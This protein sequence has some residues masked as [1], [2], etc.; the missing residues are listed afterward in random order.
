MSALLLPLAGC[1]RSTRSVMQTH[2][3][4]TVLDATLTDLLKQTDDRFNQIKSMNASIDISVSTGG[5][6]EGKVVDYAAFPGYL[7]LRK[8][9]DL[10][11]L[12]FTPVGHIQAVDM[13]TDGKTFTVQIPPRNRAITGS[14]A[15]ST[16]SANP[17]ENLRPGVFFD[18]LLI[19]GADGDDLVSR[20]S[21]ERI[22]Q[23]DPTQKAVFDVPEYD[24]GIYHQ[25]TGS[26]ELTSR[27]VIHIS[28]A[29]LMPYQQDIYDEKGQKVTIANYDNYQKFGDQLF[30]SVI[31]IQRPIDQLRL[32][33]TIK[34]LSTNQALE[35]NQFQLPKM[36][37]NAQIQKLP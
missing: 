3:P 16:P 9:G 37:A 30:P 24:L 26:Q 14:N 28:R 25:V 33:L 31:T 22:Y 19:R 21:D 7:L 5:G 18:S 4:S 36:P 17:I 2:A 10:R 20:T 1:F 27:R 32:R 35:D 23:P 15:V 6:K 13:V 12:L 34:K 29:T 11:V 8:P